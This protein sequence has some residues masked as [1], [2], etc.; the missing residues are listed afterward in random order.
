MRNTLLGALGAATLVVGM[1]P[2]VATARSVEVDGSRFERSGLVE[3]SQGC[4]D[5]RAVPVTAPVTLIRRGPG[6]APLGGH[7]S[8]WRTSG[9]S[10]GAGATAHVD[11]PARLS[12]FR[13]E[14]NAPSG[15]ADGRA[16][17]WYHPPGDDGHWFGSAELE[18]TGEE[19]DRKGWQRVNA[20]N[21]TFAWQHYDASGQP[22]RTGPE[23]TVAD[24]VAD[25]GGNGDGAELGFLFGCDGEDFF[26]D[27][28][29]VGTGDSIRAYDFGGFRR[30]SQVFHGSRDSGR[31]KITLGDKLSLGGLLYEKYR[32]VR[33]EGL[34]HFEAKRAGA[35]GFRRF[36]QDR[37]TAS[38]RA[39]TTVKPSR[40]TD[41]R[42][43]HPGTGTTE[44]ATSRVL[45]LVVR[46]LVG[47]RLVDATVTRGR[48]FTV[49]GKVRPGAARGIALQR[50]LD[51][52]WRTVK[53]GRTA[54]DGDYRISAIAQSA[55][56]SYWRIKASG[57]GG[58][59]GNTSKSMK[60][61]VRNPS[62]GGG[63]DDPA[64]PPPTPDDPGDPSDPPPPPPE[65]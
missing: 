8:G 45:T 15:L 34:L 46:V 13:T 55:G 36:A 4:N 28:F 33:T 47:A 64:P 37:T 5:P 29:E 16:V 19:L 27:R 51:G 44:P 25:Y 62:G 12:R 38:S 63:S 58:N 22:D 65:G 42:V 20:L 3:R 57:G 61:T 53:K 40:T 21:R 23:S 18:P 50:F 35:K 26:V 48:S 14:L 56:T 7:S 52:S 31:I 17:V 41:Y 9:G 30:R 32:D 6:N 2:A 1:V 43:R 24:F 10:F 60:L 39:E 59:A 54:R 11:K 49:S